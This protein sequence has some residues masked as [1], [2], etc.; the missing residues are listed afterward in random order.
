MSLRASSMSAS[1]VLS[2]S[3]MI[4][5]PALIV[6]GAPVVIAVTYSASSASSLS[7]SATRLTR[8]MRSLPAL[9]REDDYPHA[10]VLL[11]L[12][13]ERRHR[14]PHVHRE[15]VVLLGI[16]EAHVQHPGFRIAGAGS[17]VEPG[18]HALGAGEIRHV[19]HQKTPSA[20]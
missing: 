5:L 11:R 10:V 14:L 19:V 17:C 12:V 18:L 6:S 16:V 1:S 13:E 4:R 7:G 3:R 15:R 9:A 8:P 2:T 20:F